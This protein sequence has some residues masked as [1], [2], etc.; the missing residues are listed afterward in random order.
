MG[1]KRGQG[2]RRVARTDGTRASR[3]YMTT[4][5]LEVKI[6]PVSDVLT[7][8]IRLSY[9]REWRERGEPIDVPTYIA[10]T[11]AGEEIELSLDAESLAVPDNP[12]ATR[13][14][15]EKWAAHLDAQM[16]L[17]NV[18]NNEVMACLFSRG[19]VVEER[20]GWE[21][22]QERFH[23]E[24]PEEE[25]S[26]KVHYILTE[27]L[28]TPADVMGLSAAIVRLSKSGSVSAEVL[29]AAQETFRRAIQASP[30]VDQPEEPADPAGPLDVQPEVVRSAG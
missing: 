27:V 23:I 17:N 13:E 14:N 28:Q 5:G 9:A 12:E 26:R 18:A 11:V 24:I 1:S 8:S 10:K 15:E 6:R 16:R 2:R 20:E 29:D 3:F 30:E 7:T 25:V 21:A 4:D 22:E 19:V